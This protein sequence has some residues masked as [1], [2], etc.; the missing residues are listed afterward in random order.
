MWTAGIALGSPLP[1]GVYFINTAT[2][3]ER[4]KRRF[5]DHRCGREH[6]GGGLV[7]TFFKIPGGRVE[8][9]GIVFRSLPLA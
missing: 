8:V 9:L 3:F 7:D 4:S 2:Y 5:A 6:S 1:E